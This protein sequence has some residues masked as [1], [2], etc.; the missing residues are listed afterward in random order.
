MVQKIRFTIFFSLS[1]FTLA[2]GFTKQ[3]DIGNSRLVFFFSPSSHGQVCAT[4][5]V[6]N[7][8]ARLQW[9]IGSRQTHY[10][11]TAAVAAR[12][13]I[14]TNGAFGTCTNW[15]KS[16]SHRQESVPSNW[17]R[18]KDSHVTR[19]EAALCVFQ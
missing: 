19:G 10:T 8:K 7:R 13:C 1:L 11:A 14:E 2:A 3:F 12:A 15:T 6:T 5:T 16:R 4:C 18:S 17:V 9:F